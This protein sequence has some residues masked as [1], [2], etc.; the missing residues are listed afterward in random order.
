MGK[1]MIF[2]EVQA[3]KDCELKDLKVNSIKPFDK[4][5]LVEKDI[6]VIAQNP[7]CKRR[8]GDYKIFDVD[9]NKNDLVFKKAME[10]LGYK[11]DDYYVSN[12]IKC[13]TTDNEFMF[14][15][16]TRKIVNHCLKHIFKELDIVKPK[17]VIV[18]GNVAKTIIKENFL[19]FSKYK[20]IYIY[21]PSYYLRDNNYNV[22]KTIE[23]IYDSLKDK[24]K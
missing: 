19:M 4:D 3:C 22:N 8:G 7:S 21:H 23:D 15:S 24:L 17:K 18:L 9:E 11:R 16:D 13:S 5:R 20:Y 14:H 1:K 6:F 12:V 2:E 10:K